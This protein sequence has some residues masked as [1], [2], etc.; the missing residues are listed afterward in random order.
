M[1]TAL[2]LLAASALASV[3]AVVLAAAPPADIFM[4]NGRLMPES[5]AAAQD[6]T[7]Y[8][9]TE[10]EGLYRARPGETEFS[11]WIKPEGPGRINV[12]GVLIDQTGTLWACMTARGPG[13]A[14]PS[15]RR[16]ALPDG[17]QTGLFQGPAGWGCNDMA[18]AASGEVYVTDTQNKRVLKL[19]KGAAAL[20]PWASDPRFDFVNGVATQGG[21]VFV[22]STENGGFYRIDVGANGAAGKVTQLAAPRALGRPDGIRSL[23]PGRF[24]ISEIVSNQA[25]TG[26]VGRATL[27]TVK[28]DS[29]DYRV[30]E[31][32]LDAPCALTVDGRYVLV[33]EAKKQYHRDPS[34]IG[35]DPG[36]I[37]AHFVP[38]GDA[39]RP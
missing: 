3:P 10:G 18:V 20:V 13:G 39:G 5:L 21:A 6:G 17:K 12:S 29:V 27:A 37:R 30:L 1:K 24:L 35:K 34:L 11:P 36:P 19:A 22:S 8:I 33:I 38:L 4:K 26:P 2:R 16:F 28:G 32:G 7:V 14:V 25:A 9:G 23:A 15:L 31:G